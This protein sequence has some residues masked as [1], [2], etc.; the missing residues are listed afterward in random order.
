[1]SFQLTPAVVVP[2]ATLPD[3][4]IRVT[5]DLDG[6]IA[7]TLE[8]SVQYVVRLLGTHPNRNGPSFTGS[9]FTIVIPAGD[10]P[11]S[12]AEVVA[13]GSVTPPGADWANLLAAHTSDTGNPHAVTKAQVGLANVTN[14]A[15]LTVDQ[16]VT[17]LTGDLDTDVP[18]VKAVNSALALKA[19]GATLTAHTGN[20][21]NPH[22]VTKAQVGL[23][24]AD[25]TSDSAKPISVATQAALNLKANS[26]DLG[27]AAYTNSTAY[28]TAAQG[29]KA[30]SAVQ[31]GRAV[32]AGT[33]LTGGGDLSADRT[34]ALS[35]GSV[36]SL[37]KADVSLSED[38]IV[39]A[40][41][42]PGSDLRRAVDRPL[43][44]GLTSPNPTGVRLS[45]LLGVMAS[46]PAA[47]TFTGGVTDVV[48]GIAGAI[49]IG[50]DDPAWREFGGITAAVGNG[51]DASF[52]V[53]R[54]VSTLATSQPFWRDIETDAQ[55]FEIITKANGGKF[56]VYVDGEAVAASLVTTGGNT[57][58][59]AWKYTLAATGR[60][61]ITI[62]V[63]EKTW[64]GGMFVGPTDSVRRSSYPIGPRVIWLGDSYVGGGGIT[65]TNAHHQLTYEVGR[66]LGW[67]DVWASG[68]GGTGFR[69]PNLTDGRVIYGDRVAADVIAYAPDIV[70]VS[71]S[72]ND[73]GYPGLSLASQQA[74][75]SAVLSV[76]RSALPTVTL[77][78]V[79]AFHQNGS[80]TVNTLTNRDG[81]LVAMRQYC[82]LV[83]DPIGAISP[84]PSELGWITGT[85]KVGAPTGVGTADRLI[86]ADGVHPSDAGHAELAG[87]VASA[88]ELWQD[89]GTP[90]GALIRT[91]V[92]T[93]L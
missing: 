80:P 47:P 8:T 86:A 28:A 89:A 46:P 30:D 84:G 73:D 2:H 17:I 33:G 14:D 22:V 43:V 81:N 41:S 13:S 71:G 21:S 72:L 6:Y 52:V 7:T 9:Q 49:R 50:V 3:Q 91:N 26:A 88:W 40:L 36:A 45:K 38:D 64:F 62:F 48:S 56:L 29:A 4:S 32:T 23:S 37:A 68:L 61:R 31:P 70:I 63:A 75:A 90:R 44:R 5:S 55:V 51:V 66:I 59:A 65:N 58:Y 82:D 54:Y 16:L 18:S 11:I 25:N 15:Q 69:N 24:N 19:D 20:T 93:A 10:T 34:L 67:M 77:V 57:N 92:L 76:I 42:V 83:I 60:K 1:M 53:G 87:W 74:A 85:G 39:T 35:D 12:L 79:T 27:T 78:G